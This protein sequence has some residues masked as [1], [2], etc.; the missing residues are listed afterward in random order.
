MPIALTRLIA[1]APQVFPLP[2]LG[3]HKEI[4]NSGDRP[5]RA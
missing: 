1:I 5:S 3:G 2:D 4:G